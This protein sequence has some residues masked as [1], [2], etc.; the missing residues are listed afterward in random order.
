M[1]PSVFISYSSEDIKF[2][3][4]LY[5]ALMKTKVFNIWQDNL[6][7]RAGDKLSDTIDKAILDCD[8][9]LF[10]LTKFSLES[11]W[12]RKEHKTVLN[13]KRRVVYYFIDSEETRGKLSDWEELKG[14]ELRIPVINSKN[15][16]QPLL[17]LVAT[18]LSKY[19]D[20]LYPNVNIESTLKAASIKGINN[21]QQGRFSKEDDE[22]LEKLIQEATS[23]KMMM[24]NANRF[25][26]IFKNPLATFFKNPASKLEILLADENSIFY[27]ENS[28]LVS[29]QFDNNKRNQALVP[30]AIDRATA[31]YKDTS[32]DFFNIHKHLEVKKFN[33]QF[34]LPIIIFDNHTVHLTINLP[35]SES[36][37]GMTLEIFN[38]SDNSY[39]HS[40]IKHF[41]EVWKISQSISVDLI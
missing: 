38:D 29:S 12:V 10:Y 28:V 36:S 31:I 17:E 22:K 11:E 15:F 23:I 35:P 8:I 34:R 6:G 33:T 37:D 24:F 25:L 19:Y 9:S 27:N 32:N 4:K 39:A 1:K 7:I 41:K 18:L 3:D 30:F 16:Q 14:I 20:D 2:I 26:D 21:L 5:N 13:K 40:C